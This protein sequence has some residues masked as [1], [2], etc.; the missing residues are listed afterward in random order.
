[1][2]INNPLIVLEIDF[3][4]VQFIDCLNFIATSS[5]YVAL[6]LLLTLLILFSCIFYTN[7]KKSKRHRLQK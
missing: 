4:T 5:T 1:M 2:V 6:E 3:T 7:C